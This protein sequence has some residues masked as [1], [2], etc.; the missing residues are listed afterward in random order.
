MNLNIPPNYFYLALVMSTVL[1]FL[2]PQYNTL[3]LPWNLAGLLLVI[4]GIYLIIHSWQVFMR[5]GTLENYVDCPRMVVSDGIYRHSLN[6]M[7]VRAVMTS[8]G[9][10]VV[11]MGNLLS[12]IGPVF[13]FLVLQLIFIPYEER[14]M[15]GIFGDE[16]G[17]TCGRSGGGS[18]R[19][20]LP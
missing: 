8:V 7:Y 20:V 9:F 12:F 3:S 11:L 1:Y 14:Q 2:F 6:P 18:R 4:P 10:C 13:L 5:H 15:I 17:S 16:S 19:A